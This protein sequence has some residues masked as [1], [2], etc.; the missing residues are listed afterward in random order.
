MKKIIL[1]AASALVVAYGSTVAYLA[2]YDHK[3]APQLPAGSPTQRDPVALAAFKA[4]Q[5]S[6]CDYCHTQGTE[7]PFYAGL[8][9]AKQ[10]MQR[11]LTQGLR[12]FRLEPVMAALRNGTRPDEAD[13]A[14]IES[15]VRQNRMPPNQ[16]LLMHWHARLGQQGTNALLTWVATER[17]KYYATPGVAARFAAEPVQPIPATLSPNPAK[18]ALG[19]RLF[20][21]KALSGDGTL[22]CASCHGLDK[23]GADGLVTA[24]GINGQKGPINAPTVY[25]AAFNKW[26]FWNSRAPTLAAQAAGPVMNP[27]EM[28]SHEWTVVSSKLMARPG[29]AA[30]FVRAYGSPMANKERITDAIAAYEMT[31]ITPDSRFDRYLKG[32]ARAITEQEKRGYALFKSNGCASCHVGKA[33]GGQSM[34]IMGLDADY[35]AARGG[36]MTDADL[37]RFTETHQAADRN[38]FK[39]PTLRNIALTAPY[40]HDGSVKTLDEAVR[41]MVRNQT[42]KGRLLDKDVQDIVA[43]LKTLTGTYKGKLLTVAAPAKTAN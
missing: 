22:N 12:H 21:D 23:G 20:F 32:D 26:Q 3:T 8:P 37:G 4:M 9:V 16:Y 24:T 33:L 7:L 11:D 1:L 25:N 27:L 34:E 14:R 17:R 42:R 13:L 35:F 2:H 15:V 18:V 19:E 6:R 5:E 41:V 39:V 38:R 31:L 30:A 40:M 43:F 10:L 36:A 28:G 29:Y